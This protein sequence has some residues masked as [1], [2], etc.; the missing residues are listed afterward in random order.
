MTD[1][2][3]EDLAAQDG[4]VAVYWHDASALS[5]YFSHAQAREHLDGAGS[6]MISVGHI[7]VADADFVIL[8][9]SRSYYKWGDL[10]RIPRRCIERITVLLEGRDVAIGTTT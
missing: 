10:L 6:R 1:L 7:V 2:L 5:G 8:A 3:L 4:W 9:T